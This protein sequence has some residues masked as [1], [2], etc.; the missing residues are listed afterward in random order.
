MD[1]DEHGGQLVMVEALRRVEKGNERGRAAVWSR[2]IAWWYKG[3]AMA[4]AKEEV[5][6]WRTREERKFPLFLVKIP[7]R[8][9]ATNPAVI[10]IMSCLPQDSSDLWS[11]E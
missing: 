8:V 6:A 11:N 5:A 4:V 10:L 1:L 7:I 2:G 3:G 9:I